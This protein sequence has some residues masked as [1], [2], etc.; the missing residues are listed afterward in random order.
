MPVGYLLSLALPDD[1][2]ED[3][4][5]GFADGL[6]GGPGELRR[7]AVRRR[8]QP[9]RRRPDGLGRRHRRGCRGAHGAPVRR[10][11]P[12]TRSSSPARSATRRWACGCGSARSI[13]RRRG[14]RRTI[15]S[16]ATCIPQPRVEL[17]PV[18]RRY[19]TS[20]LDI[21]DGLVG[22]FAHICEAPAWAP[23]SRRRRCRCRP[24]GAALAAAD[25][26]AALRR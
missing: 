2:A 20:A 16:T 3:W 13:R 8:H 23:R 12:A 24:G 10:R 6:D 25:A 22:D 21:S 7:D 18:L 15:C 11:G 9:R 19:A 1:W 17:A 4:I 14:G 26:G 5:A